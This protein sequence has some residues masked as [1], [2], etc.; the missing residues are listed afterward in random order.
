MD[1]KD[2]SRYIEN[3][4]IEAQIVYLPVETPTVAAAAEAV[5]VE[6][7]QIGKSLL[8]LVDGIPVLVITAGSSRVEYKALAGFLGVNRKRIRLANAEQ[9][10]S[11]TGYHVGT[12]PPFGHL[13]VINSLLDRSIYAQ[14]ELYV[15]GGDINALLRISSTELRRVTGAQLVDLK[16]TEAKGSSDSS[17]A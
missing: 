15:G 11:H 10:L 4:G 5:N 13:T 9:V 6:P 14:D 2:L 12:V 16:K 3:N 8:F 1:S 17:A 7:D